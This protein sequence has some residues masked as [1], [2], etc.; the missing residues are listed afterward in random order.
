[1]FGL[2][3][4]LKLSLSLSLSLSFAFASLSLEV[5]QF[6]QRCEASNSR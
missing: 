1:M 2:L 6:I 3:C 4:N 5:V